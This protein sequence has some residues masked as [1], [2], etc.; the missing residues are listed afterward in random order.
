M[1]S[2][3]QITSIK[4]GRLYNT[5]N[6]EHE[7]IEITVEVSPEQSAPDTVEMITSLR[8]AMR[9]LHP[10]NLV[11]ADRLEAAERKL[12]ESEE[13]F[14]KAPDPAKEDGWLEQR[15]EQIRES[16]DEIVS[17]IRRHEQAL[18]TLANLGVRSPCPESGSRK[19]HSEGVSGPG[20]SGAN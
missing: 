11:N 6:Y 19:D 12:K 7:R 20:A 16:R 17:A 13:E 15:L 18:S 10:D 1:T 14:Q 5:G 9:D 4:I 3:H 2:T 8:N